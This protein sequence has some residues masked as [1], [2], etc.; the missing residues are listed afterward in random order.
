MILSFGKVKNKMTTLIDKLPTN[1]WEKAIEAHNENFSKKEIKRMKLARKRLIPYTSRRANKARVHF[2]TNPLDIKRPRDGFSQ[3]ALDKLAYL[4]TRHVNEIDD[5]RDGDVV[6]L[7]NIFGLGDDDDG[8]VEYEGMFMFNGTKIVNFDMSCDADDVKSDEEYIYELH[9]HGDSR[10]I[11]THFSVPDRYPIRYW[12]D[13]ITDHIV[14]FKFKKWSSQLEENF[15]SLKFQTPKEGSVYTSGQYDAY[16]YYSW[17]VHNDE[18]YYVVYNN[19]R[20]QDI[21]DQRDIS[22]MDKESFICQLKKRSYLS[23]LVSEEEDDEDYLQETFYQ[24][25]KTDKDHFLQ[26]YHPDY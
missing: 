2:Y 17:F 19:L 15:S 7:T 12:T 18:R 6:V 11:P 3:H 23:C 25:L 8:G 22:T 4:L 26:F 10:Y 1:Q 9:D 16:L 5:L 24:L 21:G 20:Q 14:P 13:I